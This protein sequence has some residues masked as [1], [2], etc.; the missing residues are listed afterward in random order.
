M[1]LDMVMS[2]GKTSAFKGTAPHWKKRRR[3]EWTINL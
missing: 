1:S 3:K 2:E